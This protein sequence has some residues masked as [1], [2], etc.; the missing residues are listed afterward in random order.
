MPVI[1]ESRISDILLKRSLEGDF[2]VG[3][4]GVSRMSCFNVSRP[5]I[6]PI[7]TDEAAVRHHGRYPRLL[8]PGQ[9]RNVAYFSRGKVKQ[10][11]FVCP[12]VAYEAH[13]SELNDEAEDFYAILGV[14]S[15]KMGQV[16]TFVLFKALT[17]S[18]D[19]ASLSWLIP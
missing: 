3:L 16:L 2:I 11:L 15:K 12:S 4:F 5:V 8:S 6:G 14:V 19:L 18:A 10:S 9:Q 17:S 1:L 13:T 7:C